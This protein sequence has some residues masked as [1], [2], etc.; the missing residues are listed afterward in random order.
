[1]G[2][3]LLVPLPLL[4][5]D[6]SKQNKTKPLYELCGK[7]EENSQKSETKDDTKV[8]NRRK[9]EKTGALVN[10]KQKKRKLNNSRKF[11]RAK[12]HLFLFL[13]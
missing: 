13:F 12:G 4:A 8:E 10:T 3:S 11:P 5:L 9:K 2:R 6:K 1:M 7:V